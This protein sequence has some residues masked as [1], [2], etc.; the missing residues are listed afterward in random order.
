MAAGVVFF[1]TLNEGYEYVGTNPIDEALRDRMT[2]SIRMNYV[3]RRV[4][5]SIL[6]KRTSVDDDTAGKLTEFAR[7][8]RRNPK[9]GV[10]VSTRQLLGASSL[11]VEGMAIQD[12]VLFSVVNSMGED[13]DRAALLQ[14][15]QIIGNVD[16]AYVSQE[17]QDD[18]S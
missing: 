14:A 13:V 16:D 12:A 1:I 10:P 2:Y 4:E 3:P 5:R 9:I 7:S 6:V 15:L 11:I 18:D 8:V 17:P